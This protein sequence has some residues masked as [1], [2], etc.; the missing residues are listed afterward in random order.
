MRL[1]RPIALSVL[2]G[3]AGL[4][5]SA[6]ELFPLS[7]VRAGM[8]GTGR[9]VFQGRE[10]EE[11]QVEILGVLENVGPK[12]S[13]ILARLAGGPLAE[14]GVMA[15]MSGSPVFLDGKPA[16]AIAFTFPFSKEPI[17]GIRPIEEMIASQ[18]NGR[19]RSPSSEA[20]AGDALPRRSRRTDRRAVQRRVARSHSVDFPRA[21]RNWCRSPRRSTWPAFLNGL[22]IYLDLGCGNWG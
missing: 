4:A 20:A 21:S 12:Q 3:V 8:K 10:I 9:T 7:E 6:G 13:I 5:A 17:A 19:V 18:R 15:G 1:P 11:F 2:L 22:S 14:T 16:G